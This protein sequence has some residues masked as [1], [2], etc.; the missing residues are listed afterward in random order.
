MR[1]PSTAQL[2]H[3]RETVEARQHA[4]DDEDVVAAVL[5]HGEARLAIAGEVGGMPALLQRLLKE[6]CRLS[7]VFDHQDAHGVSASR[8]AGCEHSARYRHSLSPRYIEAAHPL[9]G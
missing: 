7:V 4:V 2:L 8:N 6:L 3:H 1:L 9:K 5:G